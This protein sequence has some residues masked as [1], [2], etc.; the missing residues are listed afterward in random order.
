M[1]NVKLHSDSSEYSKMVYYKDWD[2]KAM[3]FTNHEGTRCQGVQLANLVKNKRSKY[4][5]LTK[6]YQFS[7]SGSLDKSTLNAENLVVY[8]AFQQVFGDKMPTRYDRVVKSNNVSKQ[9]Q[10]T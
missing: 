3:A 1:D 10:N 8:E 7:G 4:M 9:I 6:P 5:A 2:E